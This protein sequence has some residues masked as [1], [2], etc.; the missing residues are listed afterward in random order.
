MGFTPRVG[1]IPT[2]GTKFL[3]KRIKSWLPGACECAPGNLKV[4]YARFTLSP[5][6]LDV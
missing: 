5:S 2:S 6:T 4:T 1:S 3:E